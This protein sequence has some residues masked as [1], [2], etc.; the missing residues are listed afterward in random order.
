MQKIKSPLLH[1][2]QFPIEGLTRRKPDQLP[3]FCFPTNQFGI[4]NFKSTQMNPNIALIFTHFNLVSH[5][6]ITLTWHDN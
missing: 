3:S 6:S 5:N 1:G 2:I 4:R